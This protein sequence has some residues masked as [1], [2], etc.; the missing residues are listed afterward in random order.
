ME[1]DR[2]WTVEA[3]AFE[4]RVRGGNTGVRINES[5]KK[6]KGSIF[7]RSEELVWLV[8]ALEVVAEADKPEIFWDQSRAGLPRI[9][10]QKRSNKHGRFLSI[11]EFEGRRRCGIVL[12]PEGRFGQGW[13][14]LMVELDGAL[15]LLRERRD[16]GVLK[17]SK[18]VPVRRNVSTSAPVRILG[19]G[20]ALSPP[21]IL[22]S[23]E[24]TH[25]MGL[26][27]SPPLKTQGLAGL[28][29]ASAHSGEGF[30][31][32]VGAGGHS[33]DALP[34]DRWK[35]ALLSTAPHS[36][37]V[38]C[39]ASQGQACSREES[40]SVEGGKAFNAL[41]ELHSCRAWL[42]K[43]RGEVDAGLRR[44]DHLLKGVTVA[45]PAQ[46]CWALGEAPKPNRLPKAP[47]PKRLPS[48]PKVLGL[49]IGPKVCMGL[50]KKGGSAG[51]SGSGRVNPAVGQNSMRGSVGPSDMGGTIMLGLSERPNSKV[52][53]GV[54][55]GSSGLLNRP[56][57]GPA[58]FLAEGPAELA[59]NR[60]G[61]GVS[62][63]VKPGTSGLGAPDGSRPI[64]EK[65]APGPSQFQ[66]TPEGKVS[67]GS[68]PASSRNGRTEAAA[69]PSQIRVYQRS[70]GWTSK[71]SQALVGSRGTGQPAGHLGTPF[72]SLVSPVRLSF[73]DDV[74]DTCVSVTAL[75]SAGN[76]A[77]PQVSSE[78][79]PDS[80]GVDPA[81]ISVDAVSDSG[82][83]EAS[84]GS[85]LSGTTL[86][87]VKRDHALLVGE[88]VGMTSDGQPGLLKEFLGKI[89]VENH[90][91]GT[92]GERGSHDL[93]EF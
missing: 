76:L 69:V 56:V 14:R 10:T 90:C 26:R 20:D 5:S 8:G 41:E 84:A 85:G 86:V 25:E 51:P 70:R 67:G 75:S 77:A 28:V 17:Q 63:M 91:R 60:L 35:K 13:A 44:L 36:Q 24:A 58:G 16:S 30:C 66:S 65:V 49:S 38:A 9:Q 42:R 92:G 11:E 32:G 50:A 34:K 18:E 52:G 83:G 72:S 82:S 62:P 6:K 64:S 31:G 68:S 29:P 43:L 59:G 27:E 23:S 22:T 37:G 40:V 48:S 4:V 93:N 73:E 53:S 79:I 54:S 46:G 15:S 33:G 39:L 1:G 80:G 21:V 3:K 81:L 61:K 12:V 57:S 2:F 19:K 78:F 71:R 45:G 88:V 87:A 74:V 89:I 47:K 55:A 7:V